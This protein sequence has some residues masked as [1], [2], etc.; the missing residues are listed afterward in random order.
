MLST[1]RIRAILAK[2]L[3]FS[4]SN[5]IVAN[6]AYCLSLPKNSELIFLLNVCLLQ[7]MKTFDEKSVLFLHVRLTDWRCDF[8]VRMR[9]RTDSR[10][11]S[12]GAARAL[13]N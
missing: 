1:K 10:R 6:L 13:A 3:I 9:S 11:A 5:A 12:L 4:V 8:A 7:L 2:A